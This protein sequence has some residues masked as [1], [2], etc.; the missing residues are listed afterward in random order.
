[1]CDTSLSTVTYGILQVSNSVWGHSDDN[2]KAQSCGHSTSTRIAR[3][4]NYHKQLQSCYRRDALNNK[5]LTVHIQHLNLFVWEPLLIA[6]L[7][8]VDWAPALVLL[9]HLSRAQQALCPAHT[10]CA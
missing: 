6:G 10:S 4:D 8:G 3:H 1:M 7:R 5:A 2:N 9:L